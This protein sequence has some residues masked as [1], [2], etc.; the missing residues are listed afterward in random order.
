MQHHFQVTHNIMSAYARSHALTECNRTK[1]GE[2]SIRFWRILP[3][4]MQLSD[5]FSS[6]TPK[7]TS[8]SNAHELIN[9]VYVRAHARQPRFNGVVSYV[10]EAALV[11]V[12][13]TLAHTPS[14]KFVRRGS[15]TRTYL[16][17]S[18]GTLSRIALVSVTVTYVGV[19][20][21]KGCCWFA[22]NPE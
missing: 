10:A 20:S 13:R 16:A 1:R 18:R 11:Y 7:S 6:P 17:P 19:M 9:D 8:Y 2:R 21:C 22:R 15:G 12:P 4:R 3:L 5:P 14:Q